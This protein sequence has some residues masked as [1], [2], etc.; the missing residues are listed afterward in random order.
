MFVAIG[1]VE[2]QNGLENE[3]KKAFRNCPRI[4]SGKILQIM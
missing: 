4:L 1:S 3:V 2:V